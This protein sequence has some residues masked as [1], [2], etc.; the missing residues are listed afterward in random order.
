MPGAQGELCQESTV[1]QPTSFVP[2][3]SVRLNSNES[4][5]HDRVCSGHTAACG[6]F[7]SLCL[8]PPQ[9]VSKAAGPYGCRV[10]SATVGPASY[11]SPSVLAETTGS[12]PC[13]ASWTPAYQ[14]R[15][16][17]CN[18]P[19]PLDECSM[20][21]TG[22]SSGNG[23]QEKGSLD[24][25]FQHGLGSSLRRK[26]DIRPLV[27]SRGQSAHQLPR[28]AGGMSGLSN[29]PAR[30]KRTP[31]P[32]PLGQHDCGV[33]HKSSGGGCPRGVFLCW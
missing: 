7:Q 15:P 26:T 5:G 32:G 23:L 24:R 3:N 33:L 27:E 22:R 12:I 13:V 10:S 25:C 2:G 30:P 17:L 1:P 28:N 11:A 14:G 16:G 4:S 8:S 31:R 18:S 21:G 19:G 29:L 6:L 20:D 9:D